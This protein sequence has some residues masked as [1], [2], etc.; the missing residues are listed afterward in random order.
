MR[1]VSAQE[2]IGRA[3]FAHARRK[4]P[5]GGGSGEPLRL[6]EPRGVKTTECGRNFDNH[7]M[8]TL[9]PQVTVVKVL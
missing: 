4:G 1:A 6:L 7:G 2:G 8:H 5:A 9:V 3:G